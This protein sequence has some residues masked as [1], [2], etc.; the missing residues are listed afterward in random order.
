MATAISNE[1][2]TKKSSS[3]SWDTLKVEFFL[4]C[5]FTIFNNGGISEGGFK[6]AELTKILSKFN[7]N[8]SVTYTKEQLAS[9]W[10]QLK[11]NTLSDLLISFSNQITNRN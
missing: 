8:F 10:G 6:S 5:C 2:A 3:A 4:Q 7:S 1:V 9:K 11:L